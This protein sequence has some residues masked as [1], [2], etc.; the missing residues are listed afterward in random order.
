MRVALQVQ[1][2]DADHAQHFGGPVGDLRLAGHAVRP[3]GVGELGP[4]GLDRVEGVHRALHDDRQVLPPDHGQLLVGESHHVA[5]LEDD[6]AAGDRGRWHQELG[7]G[8]QQRGLAAA[9]FPHDADELARVQVEA[10]L[11]HRE[12]G[13][14]VHGVLDRQVA[15]LQHGASGMAGYRGEEDAVTRSA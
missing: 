15:D 13:S 5:A 11:V 7:D 10:D 8:E 2:V 12:H 1:R 3:H 4:D 9:G 14:A 6:T